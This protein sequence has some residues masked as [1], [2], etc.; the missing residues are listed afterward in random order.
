LTV[1][2]RIII[3]IFIGFL[4]GIL[5]AIMPASVVINRI[6]VG[7]IGIPILGLKNFLS[8][9]SA[10]GTFFYNDVPAVSYPFTAMLALY[11]FSFLPLYLIAPIFCMFISSIF[12]YALM[13]DG[14]IWRLWVLLSVPF[15]SALHSVQFVPL[16]AAAILLPSLLPASAIKPQLGIVLI[17]AGTWSRK[18][19]M[20]TFLFIISS[21][22]IYPTWP[23]EWIEN[24]NLS[25]YD[26]TIPV[27]HGIGCI[28]L[29]SCFKLR[30][31][32]ARMLFFMSLVPQR[33]WYDQLMLCLIPE[34]GRQLN[35]LLAGSWLSLLLSLLNSGPGWSSGKQD[36]ASWTYVIALQYFP[37]LLIIYRKEVEFNLHKLRAI[38]VRHFKGT[39]KL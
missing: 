32:N 18:T 27:F 33:L 4:A 38:F 17:S 16:M 35:I 10:Y 13:Y 36:S 5:S 9:Q 31:K 3:A 1:R 2:R 19:I 23:I 28:L 22:I 12:A 26:A 21:V 24:G 34:T 6:Q 29:L 20:A 14:T 39:N 8:G 37:A 15:F 30:D 11:P 25:H 7:D